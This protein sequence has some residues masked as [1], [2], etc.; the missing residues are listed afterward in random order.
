MVNPAAFQTPQFLTVQQRLNKTLTEIETILGPMQNLLADANQG[1]SAS[2]IL[3]VIL[4]V[5]VTSPDAVNVGGFILLNDSL[6]VHYL[7]PIHYMVKNNHI[8]VYLYLSK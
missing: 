6:L 3:S 5:D 4:G 2:F 7:H 1:F 8:Y